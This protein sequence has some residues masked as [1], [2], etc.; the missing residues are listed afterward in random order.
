MTLTACMD[1]LWLSL[2]SP[3]HSSYPLPT[4][5]TA[6]YPL[7]LGKSSSDCPAAVISTY[8]LCPPN[9]SLVKLSSSLDM[10]IELIEVKRNP[11]V[12]NIK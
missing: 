9:S 10:L 1:R 12:I 5:H 11:V 2:P 4:K 7:S 3:I 8:L 6:T